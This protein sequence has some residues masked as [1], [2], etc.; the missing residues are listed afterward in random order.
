MTQSENSI[1]WNSSSL[2]FLSKQYNSITIQINAILFWL[3][4]YRT[5]T[6]LWSNS[7]GYKNFCEKF[8]RLIYLHSINLGDAIKYVIPKFWFE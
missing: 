2:R 5:R 4:I 1:F 6:F 8:G 7:P 3:P